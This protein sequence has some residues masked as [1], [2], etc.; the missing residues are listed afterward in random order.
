VDDD[1]T[2]CRSILAFASETPF[3]DLEPARPAQPDSA[4]RV[5]LRDECT[6]ATP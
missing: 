1:C 2:R 6:S 5:D 4:M 3:R